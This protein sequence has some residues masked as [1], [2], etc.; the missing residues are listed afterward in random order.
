MDNILDIRSENL[1]SDFEINPFNDAHQVIT[2]YTTKDAIIVLVVVSIILLMY[3]RNTSKEV[4]V[5]DVT[6]INQVFKDLHI[7]DQALENSIKSR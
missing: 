2:P 7:K 1:F 3:C 4:K 5:G 6:K